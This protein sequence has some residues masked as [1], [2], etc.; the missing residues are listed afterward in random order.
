MEKKGFIQRDGGITLTKAGKN[1]AEE[2]L[3]R[4]I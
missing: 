1:K 4:D 3:T 2:I